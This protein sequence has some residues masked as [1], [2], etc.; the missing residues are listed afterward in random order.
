MWHDNETDKDLL[1]F[2]IHAELI[3]N[4]VTDKD[5][6]ITSYSIHYTKLYD[7]IAIWFFKGAN[8]IKGINSQCAFVSTNSICQ[9]LQV[10]LLWPSIFD[11]GI[12]I[13]FAHTSFKWTNNAKGNA[14]VT[15]AIIGLANISKNTKTIFANGMGKNVNGINAYLSDGGKTIVQRRSKPL[16]D[17]NE[18][19]F[20]NMPNDGG[21]LI[22]SEEENTTLLSQN[23]EAEKYVKKLLGAQEFIRGQVRYCLWINDDNKED[24]EKIPFIENCIE[25]TR[26]HRL[27]SKDSS[28]NFV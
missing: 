18:M 24:A 16:A 13:N 10:G 28:Y 9:G 20:G 3:K 22:L 1:G 15:V 25:K 8:Y 19:S 7:Y 17:F 4:I 11:L 2:G 12:E 27:N 26:Q 5:I 23:P 21:G 6:V 14:G